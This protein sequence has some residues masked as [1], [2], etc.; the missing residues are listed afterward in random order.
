MFYHKFLIPVLNPGKRDAAARAETT[1]ST[2]ILVSI[3]GII[4]VLPYNLIPSVLLEIDVITWLPTNKEP[5]NNIVQNKI[6]VRNHQIVRLSFKY[7]L[8]QTSKYCEIQWRQIWR[9][10]WIWM[11]ASIATAMCA[12]RQSC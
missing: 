11:K 8:S 6:L 5:L 10:R 3:I 1:I 12:V 7:L 2:P 4:L 9:T